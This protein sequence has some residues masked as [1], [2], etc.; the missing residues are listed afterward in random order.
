LATPAGTELSESVQNHP[1]RI[2]H[3]HEVTIASRISLAQIHLDVYF[4]PGAISR[5]LFLEMSRL[6]RK[7]PEQLTR[8]CADIE[9]VMAI[10]AMNLTTV[11]DSIYSQIKQQTPCLK[12]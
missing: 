12:R 3:P 1:V 2:L 6:K 9:E 7:A 8:C 11:T 5:A 4:P 10:V